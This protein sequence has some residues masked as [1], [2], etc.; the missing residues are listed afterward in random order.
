MLESLFVAWRRAR[1]QLPI[2]GEGCDISWRATFAKPEN[3]RIG[4]WVFIGPSSFI[5]G[6]GTVSIG[7]GSIISSR[8]VVLSSNHN[9]RERSVIP[10]GGPD[11]LRPVHIGR[12]V[13]IGFGAI[14]LPGVS[15]GDCCI[16]GAGAVVTRDVPEGAIVA[17]NPAVSVGSRDAAWRALLDAEAYYLKRKSRK[18]P[19]V[20]GKPDDP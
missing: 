4:D 19:E 1:G 20:T 3:I 13:W 17:G 14:V 7:D 10:Y 9:H 8:V 16:V 18:V 5:E 15:L 11:V 2:E 12:A 6:K